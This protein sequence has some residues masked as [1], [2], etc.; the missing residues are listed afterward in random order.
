MYTSS[1]YIAE[2]WD[3]IDTWDICEGTNY[4]KHQWHVAAR[5][6]FGCP[7]GV[8][9]EDFFVFID[10]WLAAGLPGGQQPECTIADFDGD[11]EVNLPDFAIFGKNWLYGL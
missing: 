10:C 1:T 2:D 5:G 9:M 3:F 6:D 11:N 4:P 8:G 7:D